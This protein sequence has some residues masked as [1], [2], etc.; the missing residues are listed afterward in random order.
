MGEQGERGSDV[1]DGKKKGS[2]VKVLLLEG[3]VSHLRRTKIVKQVCYSNE[4]LVNAGPCVDEARD[5]NKVLPW[6]RI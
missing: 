4:N 3:S 1:Y 2:M 5:T 6:M